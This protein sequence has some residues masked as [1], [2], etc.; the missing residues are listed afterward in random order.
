MSTVPM[1]EIRERYA[2]GSPGGHWFDADTMRFFRTRLTRYGYAHAD[3]RAFFVTRETNPSD[4]T[5]YSVRVISADG[6]DIDTAGAFHSIASLADARR[7]AKAYA[8]GTDPDAP[9][10]EPVE[11][12]P[13]KERGRIVADG[14]GG[15]LNP[16]GH[17]E[18]T[19][20]VETDLRRRPWN[21]GGMSLR[22][23]TETEWLASETRNAARAM[24][25]AW[26]ANR[27]PIDSPEVRDWIH[28][29][30]G[31]FR[32]CFRNPDAGAEQWHAGKMTID[33]KRDPLANPADHAG[34]NLIRGFYPEYNPTA[35][36]FTAAY[37]GTRE[38]HRKA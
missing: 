33:E 25:K 22:A 12:D 14:M 28:S 13:S 4:K 36:D 31:Y 27:A 5:A 19:H 23:A 26:E 1:S 9:A 21:R 6:S 8:N 38:S 32:H 3:G 34:V 10:P 37:W 30:L 2:K 17:P 7:R 29:T 16:P 15:F 35:E 11:R 18:H 20:H 24:L